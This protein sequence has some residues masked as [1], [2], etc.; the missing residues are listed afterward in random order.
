MASWPAG[1]WW[2]NRY[3]HIPT[4]TVYPKLE[5]TDTES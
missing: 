5:N 4:H 1:R 2:Y 3:N